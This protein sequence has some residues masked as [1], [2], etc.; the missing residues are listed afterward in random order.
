MI[1]P[2]AIIHPNAKVGENTKIGPY[3]VIGKDVKVGA[4][5]DLKS[6]V[7]VDG[8]VNIGDKT[9]IFSFVSIG[10]DP[11]DL[12]FKGEK[13]QIIIGDNCKIREYCTINPG[14]EGGGRVTKVGDNCLLMVGTHVAHDCLI[15]DNVIF[16]NHST[17]AGHV[18]IEKNVV[19]GALSAIHQFTRIGEGAMIGGMSGITGDVPPF[20]TAMGNRAKLNGLN[21]VGL[22]RNEISKV[23]ISELRKVY[24]FIFISKKLTFKNRVKEIEE[25]KNSFYTINKLLGFISEESNRSFCLP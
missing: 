18:N 15:S 11:Q 8:E 23:E 24:N 6:H 3:C 17:L 22:K 14:T 7:V 10:S 4:N 16:A 21:I 13:T 1:H 25:K 5:C 19:V 9:N 12:K 2:T 20:C